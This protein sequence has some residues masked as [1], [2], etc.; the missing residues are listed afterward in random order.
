M[1]AVKAIG[2]IFGMFDKVDDIVYEPIKLVCDTLRQ[3]LKQLDAHNEK[4]KAE[5]DQELVKQL[6]QFEVDLELDKKQREMQLSVDERRMEEEI[7][8]MILDNDLQ[9]REDM[10]QLEMKYRKEMAEAAAQL[11]QIMANMQ[12]ETRSKILALYTEKEKEYLD[13]QDKYKKQMFDTVKSLR[14]TFPDGTGEDIIR[15]EVKTQLKNISERSAAF[16]KLMNED[17][18]K[19]FGIIDSGMQEITGLATKYF[20]PAE[21]NQPALTQNVV[22]AIEMK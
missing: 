1:E 17:M 12:V 8:Q 13:L 21:A 15:D 3:P 4:K 6:K 19:V 14:D 22:D 7:N 16:S 9:R 20:Q 5:H 10:V 2:K 11:A 18:K